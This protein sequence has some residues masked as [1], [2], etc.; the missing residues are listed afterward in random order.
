MLFE[1]IAPYCGYFSVIFFELIGMKYV[2][3]RQVQLFYSV[4]WLLPCWT[5]K[6]LEREAF[7]AGKL[8]LDG[9]DV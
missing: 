4:V 7:G 5:Y 9:A 3:F 6:A 2:L 1:I 8:D